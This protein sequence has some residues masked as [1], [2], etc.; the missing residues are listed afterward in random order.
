MAALDGHMDVHLKSLF[1][2]IVTS[3][4]KQS[5]LVDTKKARLYADASFLTE[6][7]VHKIAL[8]V[9]ALDTTRAAD[10]EEGVIDQMELMKLPEFVYNPFAH[11]IMRVFD[12]DGSGGLTLKE[13]LD[14][15]SVF[16]PRASAQVKAQTLF[17]LFDYDEDGELSPNDVEHVL[18]K[19]LIVPFD[20]LLIGFAGEAMTSR[21]AEVSTGMSPEEACAKL[22]HHVRSWAQKI[23]AEMDTTST[24]T[25]AYDEWEDGIAGSS[26]FKDFFSFSV[27]SEQD[28]KF[29]E[30]KLASFHKQKHK[31]NVQS[32]F[33]GA[34]KIIDSLDEHYHN[35]AARAV[36]ESSD[37]ELQVSATH[38]GDQDGET[39]SAWLAKGAQEGT[40]LHVRGIGA[41][42]GEYESVEALEQIFAEYGEFHQA[43][44]RHRVQD[45]QNTSWA[46]VTM[47]NAASANRALEA[48][49][50]GAVMAGDTPLVV[51][52]YSAK[53]M[54]ETS[55][56]HME[57]TLNCDSHADAVKAVEVAC[58]QISLFKSIQVAEENDPPKGKDGK[59]VDLLADKMVKITATP[60][61][62]LVRKGDEGRYMFV[63]MQGEVGI[64]Q[65]E[66]ADTAMV[67]L[68]VDEVFGARAI[69]TGSAVGAFY[70]IQNDN[71]TFF[72]LEDQDLGIVLSASEL[73]TK[74][75]NAGPEVRLADR[76]RN[77]RHVYDTPVF[78]AKSPPSLEERIGW[79]AEREQSSEKQEALKELKESSDQVI[80]AKGLL[81]NRVI[82]APL[83][84]FANT[85]HIADDTVEHVASPLWYKE[86][87]S[88]Q[89]KYGSG[90]STTFQL[91]R[92]IGMQNLKVFL[93]WLV[94]VIV[95][96]QLSVYWKRNLEAGAVGW[97]VP[98]V[99]TA[100]RY[101]NAALG[102]DMVA[103]SALGSDSGLDRGD[104]SATNRDFDMHMHS[105]YAP[106]LG[107]DPYMQHFSMFYGACIVIIYVSQ[108][109]C[110]GC[111]RS[112]TL[113]HLLCYMLH[114]H[115]PLPFGLYS[116]RCEQ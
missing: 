96:R 3:E 111:S 31:L 49:A 32:R 35:P 41:G 80:Q 109:I 26:M 29:S 11:R 10:D 89:S 50:S 99:E 90:V 94:L 100:N 70:K 13:I 108:F 54:A 73:G 66:D 4:K 81:G 23:V 40:M 62:M 107:S 68:G 113:T 112:F 116:E 78:K 61:R 38:H 67:V 102:L 46:L 18:R 22:D 37:D 105:A 60:G 51:T 44:I 47:K 74:I 87:A 55:D 64:Y 104:D 2:T 106:A 63:I 7:E 56:G 52:M 48:A 34:A 17:N 21:I 33:G 12:V 58:N 83:K 30:E 45:G 93:V 6:S 76:V 97:M 20:S 5:K 86:I 42:D 69:I 65:T 103:T 72:R 16:S 28:L 75:F 36:D 88:V 91:Q 82:G 57:R 9:E 95:P 59:F 43:T 77:T 98:D 71:A 84:A 114:C 15:Y 27:A 1:K 85:L 92:W 53:I 19:M 39:P 24:G 101:R 14:V 115:R 79:M 25:I 110:C 8:L